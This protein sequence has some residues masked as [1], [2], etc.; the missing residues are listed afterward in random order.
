MRHCR[1]GQCY[2][3][4]RGDRTAHELLH[5]RGGGGEKDKTGQRK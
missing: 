4:R 2:T 3:C 1:A 5:S